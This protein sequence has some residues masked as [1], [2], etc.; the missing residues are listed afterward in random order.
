[1]KKIILILEVVFIMFVL[2]SC[3]L[4]RAVAIDEYAESDKV[5]QQAVAA[6]ESKDEQALI[7][8]LSKKALADSDDL[9]KGISYSFGLYE[10]DCMES[11]E[12]AV[13]LVIIMES[14]GAG[15]GLILDIEL[16]LPRACIGS[17]STTCL[18]TM[19]TLMRKVSTVFRF[20]MK[21]L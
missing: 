19:P 21:K 10:G 11:K 3:T 15:C 5:A 16:Q 9:E 1:M 2:S 4:L 7:G 13:S 20:M 18:S 12:R 6:I 8:L 17:I 14:L